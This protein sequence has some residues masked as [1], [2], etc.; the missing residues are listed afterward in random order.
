M[1]KIIAPDDLRRGQFVAIY[2][3]QKQEAEQTIDSPLGEGHQLR[4][5]LPPQLMMEDYAGLKGEPLVV[6]SVNL[7]FIMVKNLERPRRWVF[8]IDTRRCE[9][10]EVSREYALLP[11]RAWYKPWTWGL[12]TRRRR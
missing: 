3:G 5:V 7:P 9:L 6:R 8:S 1:P 4:V 10:I 11:S 12:F 2:R